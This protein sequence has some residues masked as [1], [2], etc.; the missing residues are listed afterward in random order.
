MVSFFTKRT[1]T[2]V[3]NV[4]T[5][6]GS[7]ARYFLSSFF[8]YVSAQAIIKKLLLIDVLKSAV[9]PSFPNQDAVIVY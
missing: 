4:P 7:Y 2:Y 5:N 9:Q 1:F 8:L 3:N 6:D